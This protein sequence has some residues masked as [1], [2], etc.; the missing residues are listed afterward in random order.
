[1]AAGFCLL[2]S[3]AKKMVLIICFSD[4][5]GSFANIY[6]CR[7]SV[8]TVIVNHIWNIYNIE[9][10]YEDATYVKNAQVQEEGWR[11]VK[12]IISYHIL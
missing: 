10:L 8:I 3:L 4:I 9:E 2:E 11:I 12:R 7:L 1:M 6:S 5:L